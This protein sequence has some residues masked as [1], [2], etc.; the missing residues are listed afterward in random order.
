MEEIYVSKA[1]ELESNL[2]NSAKGHG[3]TRFWIMW[4]HQKYQD[5]LGSNK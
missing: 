5:Q 1:L 2:H 4:L 3:R